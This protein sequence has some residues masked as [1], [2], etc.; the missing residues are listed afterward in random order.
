METGSKLKPPPPFYQ[1]SELCGNPCLSCVE[2]RSPFPNKDI[3][4]SNPYLDMVS[5]K[6]VKPSCLVFCFW[7]WGTLILPTFLLF[8][9]KLV[10]MK[11]LSLSYLC[12]CWHCHIQLFFGAFF[13]SRLIIKPMPRPQVEGK[14]IKRRSRGGCHNCE[15]FVELSKWLFQLTKQN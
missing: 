14:A 8:G 1:T 6:K 4:V 2:I 3:D 15:Y 11:G 5:Y 12:C 13:F 9:L 7:T 10:L